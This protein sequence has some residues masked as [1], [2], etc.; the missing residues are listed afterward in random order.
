MDMLTRFIVMILHYIQ[1][2]NHCIPKSNVMLYA[3][4]ISFK[5]KEKENLMGVKTKYVPN[6]TNQDFPGPCEEKNIW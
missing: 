1:I 4:Y 5:K 3:N 6:L 2:S